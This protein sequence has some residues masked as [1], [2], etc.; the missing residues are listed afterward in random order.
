MGIKAKAAVLVAPQHIEMQEFPLPEIGEEEG[1]I[2]MEV[3]G[4]CGADWPAYSGE[5]GDFFHPPLILGHEIVGRVE[6]IGAK[7]AKR[8]K[9]KEGDRVAMEEFAPC[10]HCDYCLSGRYN[11]CMDK[12]YG[13]TSLST[14]PA[15]WGGYSE[16]VYLHP[17]AIVHK[18]ADTVPTEI[19]S[20][21]L[22]LSNGI[23][24][25]QEVGA[26]KIG[27]TVMILGPGNQGLACVVAA[28]EAG[29][30]CIIITGRSI[31]ASRLAVARELCADHTIDVDV[32]KNVLERVREITN[33]TMADTV[34]NVTSH[35]P[36][37]AQLA[38]E[39]AGHG[40]T[41][42]MAGMAHEPAEGFMPDM[43]TMKEL[44]IKGVR[45]RT[46]RELKEA[47]RLVESGKYPLEKLAT[48]RFPIEETER[49]IKTVG[50][51]GDPG[52]I[53]VAVINE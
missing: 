14:P 26:A 28:K 30:S 20:F 25:V 52:A 53:H 42:V 10:G 45:G 16:Y 13:F 35:A 46:S 43:V 22:P 39:L 2:R 29:A 51:Q 12:M 27:S 36:Q 41:V 15:L 6:R 48:H 9:V 33:G 47:V 8:W 17:H 32:D 3:T 21:F 38:I 1:L 11:V 23:R 40:G 18:M 24:W 44:T 19:A 34:I 4:V 49:A 31:D 5:L 7:A 50:R 37:T